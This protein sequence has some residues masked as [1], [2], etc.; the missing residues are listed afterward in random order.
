MV[1]SQDNIKFCTEVTFLLQG[2]CHI[3]IAFLIFVL[4]KHFLHGQVGML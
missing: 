4:H 3:H 2:A 1:I